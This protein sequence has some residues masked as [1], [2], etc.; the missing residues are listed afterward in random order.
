MASQEGLGGHAVELLTRAGFAATSDPP[1]REAASTGGILVSIIE[2][3]ARERVR[4]IG[5]HAAAHPWARIISTMPHDTPSSM[6]RRALRAGADGIVLDG[7]LDLALVPTARAV[8]AEQLS[9]PR[10]M[11]LQIAPPPL[12]FREKQILDLIVRGLT[13]RE[14][15]GELFIAES[16]VK[17]NL[18][19]IF[20]KLGAHSRSE[21]VA[22]VLDREDLGRQFA[23]QHTEGA[24]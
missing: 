2:G 8:A 13:N 1:E 6:L 4:D 14:I 24:I 7:Q 20:T 16:T 17:T 18:S 12:S 10:A 9:V 21:V 3:A 5:R 22:R 15:A 23:A 11:R 19:S